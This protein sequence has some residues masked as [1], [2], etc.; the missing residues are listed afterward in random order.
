MP[1]TDNSA[2]DT[3]SILNLPSELWYCVAIHCTQSSIATLMRVQRS[4]YS[5]LETEL[6]RR[7]SI[8]FDSD[9]ALVSQ[10]CIQLL[11]WLAQTPRR[12]ALV[13]RLTVQPTQH[14][15][16]PSDLNGTNLPCDTCILQM[17]EVCAR[18]NMPLPSTMLAEY[19][20]EL[21]THTDTILPPTGELISGIAC[22]QLVSCSKQRSENN[23]VLWA[24]LYLALRSCINILEVELPSARSNDPIFEMLCLALFVQPNERALHWTIPSGLM[25][26]HLPQR[27]LRQSFPLWGDIIALLSSQSA[28]IQSA[29]SRVLVIKAGVY[30]EPN[31]N[32]DQ[33]ALHSVSVI[34]LEGQGQAIRIVPRAYCDDAELLTAGPRMKR[35]MA[36]LCLFAARRVRDAAESTIHN[37]HYAAVFIPPTTRLFVDLTLTQVPLALQQI[38]ETLGSYLPS[39]RR[40]EL[41]FT[42]DVSERVPAGFMQISVATLLQALHPLINLESLEISAYKES[43]AADYIPFGEQEFIAASKSSGGNLMQVEFSG[44]RWGTRI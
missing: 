11:W 3:Q 31:V 35:Y 21:S 40:V 9:N 44:P 19:A 8:K 17:L 28:A 5:A 43:Q 10:P 25:V 41:N 13:Q 36:D 38:L 23:L 29:V 33:L 6:Y 1:I 39:I 32:V 14:P 22:R 4:W 24:N 7:I 16:V 18:R 37:E 26:N 27:G 20:K 15:A 42:S 2:Q 12:A 34:I 30:A